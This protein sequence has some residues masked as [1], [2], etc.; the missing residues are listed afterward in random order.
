MIETAGFL[1]TFV[2]VC[3]SVR[4]HNSC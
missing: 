2:P 4:R 1:E 3:Q